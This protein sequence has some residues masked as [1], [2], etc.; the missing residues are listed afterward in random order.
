MALH[1]AE[2][3]KGVHPD[4][5]RVVMAAA[6]RIDFTITCGLRTYEEQCRL[7]AEGKS[8]TLRSRHLTGHAID[9]CVIEDGL[10]CWDF[11]KYR[12]VA[13][14]IKEEAKRLKIPVVWGGDWKTFKDG[15]HVE[16]PEA[17][18]PAKVASRPGKKAA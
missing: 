6:E 10:A 15:P 18:Y 11:D 17:D 3:L 9:F 16:L 13:A 8:Q 12:R 7:V 1:R 2:R 4:L 14:V 5:V